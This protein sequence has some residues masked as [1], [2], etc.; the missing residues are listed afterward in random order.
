MV[1][2]THRSRGLIILVNASADANP[3]CRKN[4][5]ETNQDTSKATCF[6]SYSPHCPHE[7]VDG[8]N[9][10]RRVSTVLMPKGIKRIDEPVCSGQAQVD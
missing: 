6:P 9:L 8:E 4:P 7:C 1:K 10:V 3:E 2:I 5:C